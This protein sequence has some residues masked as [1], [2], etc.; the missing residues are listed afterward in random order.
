M[1]TL[2]YFAI[3]IAFFAVVGLF[4]LDR[5]APE[6]ET[7]ERAVA[8]RAVT[9]GFAIPTDHSDARHQLLSISRL[10]ESGWIFVRSK[11]VGVSGT[12]YSARL[13]DCQT[14]TQVYIAAGETLAELERREPYSFSEALSREPHE[15][16]VDGSIS[17]Y[18][19][20]RACSEAQAA[21]AG[22]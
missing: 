16:P 4:A 9:P 14:E 20:E 11:R 5:P 2:K 3:T 22:G 18:I 13:V 6:R 21:A 12:V 1:R 17:Y 19:G 15:A 10:Q 7:A 8:E